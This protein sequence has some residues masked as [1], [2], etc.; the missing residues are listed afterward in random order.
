MKKVIGLLV[1]GVSFTLVWNSIVAAENASKQKTPAVEVT[2][3]VKMDKK[4]TVTISGKGFKPGQEVCLL[5]TAEEGMQ[6]DIGYGLK[7]APKAD[8]SGSWST[9]WAVGDFVGAKMVKGGKSYKIT[10]TDSDYQPIAH[11]S[12][13]FVK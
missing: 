10:V 13:E 5:F 7:P 1:L 4:A 8:D 12:V 2:G 11:G 9:V 3:A 6:S